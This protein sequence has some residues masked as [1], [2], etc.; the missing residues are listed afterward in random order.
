MIVGEAPGEEKARQGKPFIGAS[1]KALNHMLGEA[2]ISRTECFV[3]NVVRERPYD[4]DL[5]PYYSR[6]KR[7]PEE[8][9]PWSARA[10][11]WISPN[12]TEGLEH[13]HRE[14]SAV[15]QMSSSL[16]ATL[17]SGPLRGSSGLEAGE[18]AFLSI[19]APSSFQPTI[20]LTSSETGLQGPV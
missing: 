18:E 10:G 13:L 2:G 6:N 15:Q 16:L 7:C 17:V 1:G 5:S 3:T 8:G 4:N 12:I 20:P 11:L 9:G 19:K 14:L